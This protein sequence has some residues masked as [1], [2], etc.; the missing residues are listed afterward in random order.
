MLDHA[1]SNRQVAARLREA[2]RYSTLNGG[3]RL[4]A[5]LV[6]AAGEAV[7][8]DPAVLDPVAAALECM[9]A[10]SLIHD[11]LPCMDDDDLRR[12]QATA[13]IRF[14]E[15]TAVLAGDALQALALELISAPESGLDDGQSRRISHMLS[16]A[17]G[18]AGMVG[19]QMLDIEA[20]GNTLNRTELENMHR[21][22]TGALIQAAVICGALC[23]NAVRD[24]QLQALAVYAENI[25][26]AFQVVDDILDIEASTETLGKTS[27]ADQAL[28]KS[29]YP[30]LLGLGESKELAQN[31]YQQAIESIAA[32]SDNKGLLLELAALVVNRQH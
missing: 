20:T 30:A 7:K 22:K 32:I 6:Y 25:G 19:G 11:D 12:G 21:C 14:D 9:H 26:L 13:H 3:K 1:L 18:H 29:T 5:L 28:G 2:M 16:S 10:Y 24:D 8:A 15:A 31:L 23:G 17:A 4:R 27:G